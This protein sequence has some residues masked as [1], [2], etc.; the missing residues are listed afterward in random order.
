MFRSKRGAGVAVAC[1]ALVALAAPAGSMAAVKVK[2]RVEGSSKT[3]FDKGVKA[4]PESLRSTAGDSRGLHPCNVAENG[5]SGGRAAS[6]VS[7]LVPARLRL[8]LNWY[9]SLA[10]FMVLSIGRDKPAGASYWDFWV[11]GKGAEALG[12]PGGCQLALEKGDSVVWA[13]TD[14]S[15]FLLS[16]KK[17]SGSSATAANFVVT[18]AGSGD[19]V[20]GASVGGSL[21]GADGR[22]TVTRPARRSR[23][24]K[25]TM[26]GAIRSN[27]VKVSAAR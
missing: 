9:E 10:G 5:G 20:A 13:V 26:A 24:V 16:L 2:L 3:L 19:P 15:Q 14:G 22:V 6:P 27:A 18:N 11:N 8:G 12:Y 25:A 23:T 21:S 7:A 17:A 1:A 4:G